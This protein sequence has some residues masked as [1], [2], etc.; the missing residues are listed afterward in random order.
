MHTGD[1]GTIDAEGYCN[2]V[3][4]LKVPPPPPPRRR[5]DE[6]AWNVASQ[7]V[8]IRGGENIAPREVEE[9]LLEH[10]G[11][12]DA[13]VVGVPDA[14]YGEVVCACVR[15][16]P[17]ARVSEKELRETCRGRTAHYKARGA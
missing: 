17:G 10:P 13:A 8:I 15:L 12:A 4:R 3:G 7:D 9:L 16:R 6:Q 14:R 5:R 1:V 11:V 2:I